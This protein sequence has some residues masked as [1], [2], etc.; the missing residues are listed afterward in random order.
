MVELPIFSFL[1]IICYAVGKLMFI[2][3]CTTYLRK[4]I[5]GG[6]SRYTISVVEEAHYV[7]L[8]NKVRY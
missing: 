7:W 5:Y 1:I 3:R 2:S 6:V 4:K 8:F